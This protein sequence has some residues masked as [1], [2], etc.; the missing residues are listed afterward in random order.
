MIRVMIVAPS[1]V[2]R[3][4]L[5]TLVATHPG[6]EFSG[7]FADAAAIEELRPDVV[8]STLLPDETRGPLA[9]DG[10]PIVLLSSDGQVPLTLEAFRSGVR[11]VL[12]ADALPAAI[13]A[14]LEAV[15]GGL[16]VLDPAELE[17]MLASSAAAPVSTEQTGLTPREREVL[18]MMAEG[19]SNKIIAWKL[20][21]S[22][23]TVKFHV[24]SIL[25]KLGAGSRT[26]AVTLGIR[27]G[28][29]ML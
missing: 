10:P 12:P 6:L 17:P 16:A 20:A 9:A 3:A 22:E 27:K 29:V 7:S 4:G 19:A 26:E 23:H 21:I 25:A 2:V 24:A 18:A 15:A 8:L 11:A 14:T 1:A 13:L 5:E 28:L